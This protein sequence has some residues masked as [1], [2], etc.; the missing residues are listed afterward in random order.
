MDL[1]IEYEA[2]FRVV[3]AAAVGALL[4]VERHMRGRAAGLRTNALVCM[5]SA[6]LIVVSRGAAMSGL[7]SDGNF[8][9]NMDPSRMAA[10]IVTGIGFLDAGAIM[11]L[12]ESLIRGLT[13]AAE[14]W[15]IAAVGIAI[16]IGAY[17]L[18]GVAA[19]LALAVLI[20]LHAVERRV[21][22]VVYR[23]LTVDTPLE[24]RIAIEGTCRSL[25]TAENVTVQET[26][27][28]IDHAAHRCTMTF[29]IRSENKLACVR[30]IGP[31]AEVDGI[32][33]L[34]LI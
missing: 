30:V 8:T 27:Y 31:L 7:H 32:D 9:L 4:G 12:K 19:G 25:L 14:I 28:T 22:S 11:R 2:I 29:S 5:A 26:G 16:G 17:V 24:R 13:T 1:F 10:G 21:S 3:L 34:E 20:G 23:T 15:F 6:L 18:A 33:R